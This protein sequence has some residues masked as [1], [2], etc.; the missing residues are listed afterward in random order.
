VENGGSLLGRVG[1]E[2]R[3]QQFVEVRRITLRNNFQEITAKRREPEDNKNRTYN[4]CKN[5]DNIVIFEQSIHQTNPMETNRDFSSKKHIL[6]KFPSHLIFISSGANRV[7][8][9]RARMTRAR[10]WRSLYW[11]SKISTPARSCL[12]SKSPNHAAPFR[13]ILTHEGWVGNKL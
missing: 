3:Y 9:P 8:V 2:K 7:L 10:P 5:R 4:C 13:R 1:L 12:G 6:L 11:R